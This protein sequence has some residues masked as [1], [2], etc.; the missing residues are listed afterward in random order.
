MK[1]TADQRKQVAIQAKNELC[2]RFYKDYIVKVHHGSYKHFKHTDYICDALQPIADGEQR[3]LIIEL[4]PRHGKSMTIT[5]TF[6]SYFIA[7]NPEKRVITTAYSDSLAR[8]FGRLNRNK[9]NEFGR[10]LFGVEV[11]DE[12]SASNDWNLEGH[13]GGMISTGIGGSITGQGADLMIIDDPIKN[14]KEAQSQTIRDNIWDEWEATLSTR[15]HHGAS[16]IVVMTRWHEDDIVGRL[17]E[18]SPH[19][20]QRIR[21]PAIAEDEDDLLGREIGEPLCPELGYG[22]E[23]AELKK[24]DVGSKTWASL[25]QQ[26]PAPASGDVILREW[27]KYYKAP[28]N[29]FD[30]TVISWDMTFKDNK[31]SDFVVGQVWGQIGADKYLLDQVRDRMSFTQALHAVVA[32][33]NKWSN[34]REILVE[35]KANGTA[36]IDSLKRK[37]SGIIP[38]NP[39][40]SKLARTEAVAPQFESGN[41]FIPENAKYTGDYVEELVSFPNAKHDDQ[42]DATSQ[43]INYMERKRPAQIITTNAW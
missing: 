41:I 10:E 42:V 7:K 8:K 3:Y 4:P 24:K 34:T 35:D 15:L 1:L 17:I 37:I 25:Y 29:K 20:W 19:P 36:I 12:K 6:P 14:N 22:K 5:E 27:L 38:I 43:A 32:L 11:S 28:P 21:M 39:D 23:W 26:S 33:K 2:R 9:L 31:D 30:R 18:R 40:S 13:N 16:V